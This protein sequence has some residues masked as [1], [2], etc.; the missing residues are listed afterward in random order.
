MPVTYSRTDSSGEYAV[1]ARSGI[2]AAGLAANSEIYQFRVPPAVPPLTLITEVSLWAIV[3]TTGFAAGAWQFRLV[4]A[5]AW[6]AAGTGGATPTLTTNGALRGAF[7]AM[8]VG[9]ETIRIATTAAL[10]A[11]TKTADANGIGSI[12]GTIGTGAFTSLVSPAAT[13]FDLPRPDSY[14]LTFAPS[15]G[16]S[17]L[18]TVPATGTW[19]FGVKVRWEEA[20]RY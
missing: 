20:D 7:A 6:S 4:P 15:E 8:R 3:D 9:A 1:D 12:A 2:M 11:G 16:F 19:T 14:P 18:A 13:L 17:I 10:G 5:R